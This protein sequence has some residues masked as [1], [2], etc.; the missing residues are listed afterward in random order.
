MPKRSPDPDPAPDADRYA[1]FDELDRLEELLE[2]MIALEIR[3][4]DELEQRIE[5]LNAR[6]D[7]AEAVDEPR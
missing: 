1:L 3:S 6:I 5:A 4:M 7:A 2:D